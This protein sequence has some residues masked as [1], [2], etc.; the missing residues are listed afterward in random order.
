MSDEKETYIIGES[1]GAIFALTTITALTG[2]KINESVVITGTI[3]P[4]GKI[5]NVTGVKEK[6]KIRVAKNIGA[7]LVLVPKGQRIDVEGIKV[8]EVKD[9]KEAGE[10]I[11]C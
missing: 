4:T 9:L 10:Y 7:E 8:I 1:A 3:F 5:G 2:K 11:F 6:E